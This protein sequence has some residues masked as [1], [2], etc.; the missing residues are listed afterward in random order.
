MLKLKFL[1][2]CVAFMVGTVTFAANLDPEYKTDLAFDRLNGKPYTVVV[3]VEYDLEFDK[4]NGK[5]IKV[6]KSRTVVPGVYD[7]RDIKQ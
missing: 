6:E 2:G 7:L 3:K 5:P 1:V 4:L